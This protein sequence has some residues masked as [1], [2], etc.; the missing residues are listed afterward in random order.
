MPRVLAID[1]GNRC[2]FAVVG[3]GGLEVSGCWH[4]KRQDGERHGVRFWRL[5]HL[6][7][8]VY[9]ATGKPDAFAYESKDGFQTSSANHQNYGGIVAVSLAW[10]EQ[11]KVTDYLA[12]QPNTLKKRATGNGR[13]EK[14]DMAAWASH[15]SGR[16]I[17]DDNEADAVCLAFV[18][19]EELTRA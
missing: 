19:H 13:A 11:V 16:D 3:D 7:S 15:R 9:G 8:E 14:A 18:V 4:L 2:G 12:I 1:P 17:R 6:L 10:C 5:F